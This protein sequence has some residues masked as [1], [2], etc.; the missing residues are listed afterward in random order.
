MTVLGEPRLGA[1]FEVMPIITRAV[2]R[3]PRLAQGR[4]KGR[5]SRLLAGVGAA[6]RCPRIAG[7]TPPTQKTRKHDHTCHPTV[8]GVLE[9]FPIICGHSRQQRSSFRIPLV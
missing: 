2:R 5:F 4:P 9:R 3:R 1:R 7:A 6:C 8:I